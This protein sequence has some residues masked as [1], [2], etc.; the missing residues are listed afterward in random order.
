MSDQSS[1]I[2]DTLGN[3]DEFDEPITKAE[4]ES[5][6]SHKLGET[7]PLPDTVADCVPGSPVLGQSS[8]STPSDH[9]HNIVLKETAGAPTDAQF[10]MPKS[11]VLALDIVNNRLYVRVGVTWKY[12][13]LI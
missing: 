7:L 3:I 4:H 2:R 9:A 13:N 5:H 11:G 8:Y 1:S 6:G 10:T 12:V